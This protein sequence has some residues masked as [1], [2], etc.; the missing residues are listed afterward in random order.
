MSPSQWIISVFSLAVL[1][2]LLWRGRSPDRW[3]ALALLVTQFSAPLIARFEIG[4][5]RVGLAAASLFL[6]CALVGLALTGRR[7]WLLAAAGVQLISLAS[8]IYQFVDPDAQ[9]WAAVT[10]RIIVWMQL[11]ALVI[12]GLFEARLAPYAERLPQRS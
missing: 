4:G 12:F 11:L 8:W 9:L 10:F 2:L 5:V 3:A 7:W 1:L 6:A